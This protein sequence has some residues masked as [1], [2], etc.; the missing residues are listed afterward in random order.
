MKFNASGLL[1]VAMMAGSLSAMGCKSKDTAAAADQ[2]TETATPEESPTTAPVSTEAAAAPGVEQDARAFAYF[3]PHGPPA[4]RVEE[5]GAARAGHFWAP[6]YY[7]WN[8]H[9]HVWHGGG[10]YPERAGYSYYGPR[11]EQRGARWGYAPGR[12]HRR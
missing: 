6:G 11:W 12:W 7:G 1:V 2:S 8:G 5:R 3:A 10:W 9:D 4:I